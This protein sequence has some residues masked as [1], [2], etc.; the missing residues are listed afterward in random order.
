MPHL[1]VDYTA[2]LAPTRPADLLPRL[3]RCLVDS[4]LFAEADIKS[5]AVR[6]DDWC[7]GTA[8]PAS[9]PRAFVH[10]R[11]AVLRG[12]ATGVRRRVAESLLATLRADWPAPAGCAAQWCVEVIE[13]DGNT[14]V[15]ESP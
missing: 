6:L 1:T 7:I 15:K 10:A 3:N 2:N 12:R 9:E 5:R 11:L 13:I 14:Y 4:G 8:D